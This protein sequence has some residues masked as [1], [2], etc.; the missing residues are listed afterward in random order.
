MPTK[1]S[2]LLERTWPK[3]KTE[4]KSIARVRVEEHV[5]SN[6][7]ATPKLPKK[8]KSNT[9][10]HVKPS[11]S[12]TGVAD[13]QKSSAD[14]TTEASALGSSVHDSSFLTN[15]EINNPGCCSVAALFDVFTFN[16]KD[17]VDKIDDVIGG[18]LEEEDDESSSDESKAESSYEDY[19]AESR[20]QGHRTGGTISSSSNTKK[21]RSIGGRS[22]RA[23]LGHRLRGLQ[24]KKSDWKRKDD[25]RERSRRSRSVPR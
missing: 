19:C 7:V 4:V 18:Y 25:G 20:R 2:F 13:W 15:P 17:V 1:R 24:R 11:G 5:L 16:L 21:N 8:D 22:G 23:S 12:P 9:F 10:I 14:S 3:K 6:D